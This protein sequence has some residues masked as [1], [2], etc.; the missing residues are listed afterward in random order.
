MSMRQFHFAAERLLQAPADVIYH[1]LADYR[2]HHRTTK[3]GGFL[4]P[5]F[6][7]LDVVEGGVGAGTVIRF[8]SS[9]GG[10]GV[11]RT[12]R[13]TEPEPGRV[14]IEDGDGEGSVFTVEPEGN[15]SRLRIETT[16]NASGLEGLLLHWF[17]A[18]LIAPVYAEEMARLETYAQ[19]H[20]AASAAA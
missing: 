11:T 8:T 5:A 7:R 6:T 15:A 20:A 4:P 1:C 12:Q 19:A 2:E 10:R 3:T 13:V 9:V 17:G 16:L 18:R 14:L